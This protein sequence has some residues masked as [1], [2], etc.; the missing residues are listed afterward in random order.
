MNLSEKLLDNLKMQTNH[1][2]LQNKYVSIIISRFN[3]IFTLESFYNK[4]N[5]K[6]AARC[7]LYLLLKELLKR[8]LITEST[9][10][11]LTEISPSTGGRRNTE[12][13]IKLIKIYESI[14]FNI[15]SGDI[16]SKNI[17]MSS[18]VSNLIEVLQN[19]CSSQLSGGKKI[20]MKKKRKTLK[21][22]KKNRRTRRRY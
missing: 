14:G 13:Y 9:I 10:I 18:N 8:E 2:L 12:A 19:I 4:L 1:I 6:N 21:Y 11:Y 3:N 7:G 22:L 5:I 20:N 16:E 17:V 15:Q